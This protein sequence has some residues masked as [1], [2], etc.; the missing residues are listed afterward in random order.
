MQTRKI[1]V[2]ISSPP[3]FRSGGVSNYVKLLME[4][5]NED[6]IELSRFEIGR[7]RENST[8]FRAFFSVLFQLIKFRKR[9]KE[10]KP[11]I[12]HLNISVY[13]KVLLT[14]YLFLK[15]VRRNKIPVISSMHGWEVS[16]TKKIMK[17]G[18]WG[19][20]AKRI[21]LKID[22]FIELS[23]QF[24]R[25]LVDLGVD[26]SKIYVLSTFVESK[27]YYPG[28]KEFFPPFKVLFCAQMY[29]NKGPFELL[30]A[31][32]RIIK[33]YPDTKFIFVGK[34]NDLENL[35]EKAKEMGIKENIG[36]TGFKSGHEKIE[37]FQ[38]TNIFVYP[39]Y[40]EGFPTV[41]LEAMAAGMPLVTTS[42]GGLADALEDGKQGLIIK[43]MPPEPEEIADK[44]VKLIGNPEL[45]KK[46]SKN[47]LKEAKEKYD[48]K[49][50]TRNIEKI[51]LSLGWGPKIN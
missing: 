10:F 29:K 11:D 43:S 25:N 48:V 50:V 38:R 21:F 12:V 30:A 26:N 3:A 8:N 46:M 23:E 47:N 4:N 13:P 39:S 34:G 1:K 2:L 16:L 27:K 32:P 5:V 7:I 35:K 51:Y 49:V 36:F 28:R 9:I 18:F 24:R 42:V 17:G 40:T 31:I 15:I 41:I 44:I 14:G 33:K 20:F 45:M 6:N 19:L 22:R 37:I